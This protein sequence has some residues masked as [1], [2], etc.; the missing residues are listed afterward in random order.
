L[1]T[2]LSNDRNDKKFY[3]SIFKRILNLMIILYNPS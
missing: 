3:V 1:D 2:L